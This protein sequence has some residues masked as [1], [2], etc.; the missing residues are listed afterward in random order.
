M[1]QSSD[2]IEKSIELAAPVSRVWSA[3]TDYREFGQWFRV[4]LKG[5]FAVGQIA[6]GHITY[7]GFEHVQFWAEVVKIEPQN[8]F[9]FHWHPYPADPKVD[10]SQEP[11]TLVTFTLQPT[12]KGCQLT[13]VESGFDRVPAHRR[14]EAFR[15]NDRGWAAQIENV[16][17][18]V[19]AQ[20]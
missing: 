7:P 19:A 18:H 13:V 16:A 15:M 20:S 4:S 11:P 10:Y 12:A 3:L 17:R 5:P 6:L 14:A 2:R 1:S 8:T 9:A